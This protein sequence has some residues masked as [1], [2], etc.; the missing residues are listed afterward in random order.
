MRP[1]YRQNGIFLRARAPKHRVALFIDSTFLLR[2][3]GPCRFWQAGLMTLSSYR[4]FRLLFVLLIC[5]VTL[6][7][8]LVRA[9]GGSSESQVCV[10]V[11]DYYLGMEDYPA[12]IRRHL[13]V[14]RE[15]PE[16][17]LA[18][19]CMSTAA[20]SSWDWTIGSCFSTW[21]WS[22]WKTVSRRP[23]PRC[24]GWRLCSDPINPRR[25]STHFNLGLTYE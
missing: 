8:V 2:S 21:G 16:D 25:I 20:R 23:R 15:H 6:W 19:N 3:A 11:A 1:R 5:S 18:H 4:A 13:V 17:A 24:C 22:I 12:A 10:P 9:S 14:I 7:P